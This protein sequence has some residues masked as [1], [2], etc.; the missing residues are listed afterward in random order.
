MGFLNSLI[1]RIKGDNADLKKKL[2]DSEKQ[3]SGFSGVVKKLGAV[4]GAAFAVEKIISFSKE[5]MKLAATLE[6]IRT[7]FEKLDQPSLLNDL[8]NATRGTVSDLN[9]MQKAVQA[10]NFKIPLE[11]LATY[12]EFATKR[13]ITTGQSVD[14]LVDR[15]VMGIG[16]KSALVLD[17]LGISLTV[18]Q[19]EVSKVGDFGVAAGN[20]IRRELTS[21]GDVADTTATKMQKISATSE[22]IKTAW[23][24]MI[25]ASAGVQKAMGDVAQTFENMTETM[26]LRQQMKNDPALTWF[27]RTFMT[28]D[29]Y[30]G[31][32]DEVAKRQAALSKSAAAMYESFGVSKG[33]AAAG[34]GEPAIVRLVGDIDKELAELREGLLATDVTRTDVIAGIYAHIRA[35]EAEKAAIEALNAERDKSPAIAPVSG[36]GVTGVSVGGGVDT[37]ALMGANIGASFMNGMDSY[38]N[39]AVFMVDNWTG[40]LQSAFMDMAN[41]VTNSVEQIFE[42]IGSGNLEGVFN[43]ILGGMGSFIA[44]IGKMLV[45]YG[46]AMLAFSI[47]SKSPDPISATAAIGAGLA[48][49]AIGSLIKGAASK[50]VQALG[51]GGGG[52]GSYS[53]ASKGIQTQTM[54]IQ[55][56]GIL[57]GSD[58]LISNRRAV[59]LQGGQ[60]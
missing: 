57:K 5:S 19:E 15:I 2:A 37:M 10:N 36:G 16:R 23:G 29:A 6:G 48:A 11:Q 18:L 52:G 60:T 22:N 46:A 35:L 21:M 39:E 41:V 53:S 30:K 33:G 4:L 55:V 45:A 26:T 20:I 3:M 1:V 44:N 12:F 7:A 13:A 40:T 42:G 51:G 59:A 54:T 58:I 38:M 9:L 24:N 28:V 34:G 27:Q 43:N 49:I 31:L 17:D 32:L 8:R 14:Q 56:E 50:G 47:L 25:N